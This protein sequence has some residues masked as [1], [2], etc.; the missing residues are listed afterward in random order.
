M[1]GDAPMENQLSFDGGRRLRKIALSAGAG[2]ALAVLPATAHA[3]TTVA[4]ANDKL[5]NATVLTGDN[6]SD[7]ASNTDH[8][9]LQ[10]GETGVLGIPVS[11]TVWYHWNPPATCNGTPAVV[12]TDGSDFDTVLAVYQSARRPRVSA[13]PTATAAN[14]DQAPPGTLTSEVTFGVTNPRSYWIQVYG[15]SLV[16]ADETGDVTINVECGG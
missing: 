11:H 1:E 9:T 16:T 3:T 5:A 12:D 6:V 15:Y 4:P 14:D 8:A 13:L 2:C 10:A 7:S